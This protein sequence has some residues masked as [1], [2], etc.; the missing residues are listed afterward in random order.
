[1]SLIKCP[2]CGKEISDKAPACIHCGCP[3]NPAPE[4]DPERPTEST[5]AAPQQIPKAAALQKVMLPTMNGAFLCKS[6]CVWEMAYS[7]GIPVIEAR[8]LLEQS[9]EYVAVAENLAQEDAEHIVGRFRTLGAA[10]AF[11]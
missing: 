7:L 5:S 6:N 1:M 11:F 4:P 8:S 3:L 9:G 10:D 2:E